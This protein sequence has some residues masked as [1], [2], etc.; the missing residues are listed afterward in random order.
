MVSV[1]CQFL[2]GVLAMVMLVGA[3]PTW[4]PF[5]SVNTTQKGELVK[6]VFPLTATSRGGMGRPRMA[7]LASSVAAM[8]TLQLAST[9]LQW[10]LSP[11]AMK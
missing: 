11:A 5:A 10:T 9:M 2:T 1:T 8:V 4:T 6:P 7:F 3:S